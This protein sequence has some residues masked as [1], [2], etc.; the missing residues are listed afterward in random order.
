MLKEEQI[1]KLRLAIIESMDSLVL[2]LLSNGT[3]EAQLF[4]NVYA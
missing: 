1:R 2:A 3:H 4:S